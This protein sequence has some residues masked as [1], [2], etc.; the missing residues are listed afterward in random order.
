M[1]WG[2][3]EAAALLLILA[4]PP[5][6]AQLARPVPR[7]DADAVEYYSHLRS[8]YFDH[9]LEFTNEFEHFGILHRWDKTQLT[10][11]G[12]RRTNFSVG[13]ALLWLPFYAA[14]DLWA[15]ARGA[16]EDG[17]SPYHIRAVCLG[18][19]VYG[20]LGLLLVYA[21]VRQVVDRGIAFWTVAA[22]LYATFLYWYL[23]DEPVMSHAGSFFLAALAVALWWPRRAALSPQAAAVLG[24]VIG[25]SATVRWQNG[26]LLLLPAASLAPHLHARLRATVLAGLAAL[27]GFVVGALPQLLAWKVLF[28]SYVLLVPPQGRDYMHFGHPFLLETFFSS[29]HGLLYWTPLLWAGYLGYVRL[30]RRDWA[31]SV[32]LLLPLVVMSYVNAC[33]A[34]WWAGGSFSNRR[35]DSVLPMLALGLAASLAWLRDAVARRPAA[36]LVAIGAALVLWNALL[37]QQYKE[38]LVPRDDT[39]SFP[40]VAE[41]DAAL[42]ARAV[43]T[44]VAWP[45]NWLFAWRHHLPAQRYDLMV[46]PYLFLRQNNL[47]GLIDLGDGRAD[48]ALLGEGWSA[49]TLCENALCREVVGRARVFAPLDGP[50]TLDVTVR[51]A[52]AGTL[53]L[54]VN[55]ARVAD[56]PLATT[57]ADLRVRVAA[58]R[59]R[60]ALNEIAL[61]ASDKAVVD[62][63]LFTRIGARP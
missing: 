1:R 17:Y 63:L 27:A 38:N 42:V 26:V 62:H 58:E 8:L 14:G 4:A 32:A 36:V 15:R 40:R 11:T 41:N 5:L 55:G 3:G 16:V 60:R 44:P 23:V 6:V 46:G 52:G 35:F 53:G 25:L 56:L 39:V 50:E 12:H 9:D 37:M 10:A 22:L 61:V 13:P 49:P 30:L 31:A 34:D 47:G 7:L 29:R 20:V 48:P 28:G 54:E 19:L 57:L 21:V 45:A 33:S 24:I 18:S 2:W 43:G 51:A 59:W